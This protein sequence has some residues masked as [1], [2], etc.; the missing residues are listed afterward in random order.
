M[1][2]Y[3]NQTKLKAMAIKGGVLYSQS[4]GQDDSK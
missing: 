4:M 2:T 3:I 1:K